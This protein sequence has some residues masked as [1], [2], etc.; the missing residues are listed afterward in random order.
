VN[1]V[2]Q[3][4]GKV[5]VVVGHLRRPVDIADGAVYRAVVTDQL[6]PAEVVS[7]GVKLPLAQSLL[8]FHWQPSAGSRWR[9][10][11]LR[12]IPRLLGG[13]L[14]LHQHHVEGRV[15]MIVIGVCGVLRVTE[16]HHVSV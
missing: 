5:L 10:K 8:S 13:G 7:V 12:L 1:T 11:L 2:E 9:V 3:L 15:A 16:L 14:L 6:V 4:A